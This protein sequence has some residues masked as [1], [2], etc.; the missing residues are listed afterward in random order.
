MSGLFSALE[1]VRNP[2]TMTG[3]SP[4]ARHLLTLLAVYTGRHGTSHPSMAELVALMGITERN[5]QRARRE[6]ERA[7]CIAVR[8]GG[9][10]GRANTYLLRYGTNPEAISTTPAPAT[11]FLRE[12]PAQTPARTPALAPPQGQ[13]QG[14]VLTSRDASGAVS[15]DQVPE[16]WYSRRLARLRA[17]REEVE[18]RDRYL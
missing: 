8:Y 15:A 5:V 3:L 7:G 11:P 4:T 12:T 2:D 14:E 6:L 10:R 9:G 18:V 1:Y 13:G 17:L 16:D